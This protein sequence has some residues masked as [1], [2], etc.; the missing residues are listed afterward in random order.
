MGLE[1]RKQMIAELSAAIDIINAADVEKLEQLIT[2]AKQ[3][4]C[5]GAGRSGLNAK[6]FAMRLM[7]MGLKAFVVGDVVTPS[8]REGDVLFVISASGSS[9]NLEGT[10]RKAISSGAKLALITT[11]P[12]SVLC[13]LGAFVLISAPTKGDAVDSGAAVTPMGT[14]FEETSY[15]L[16]D[17]MVLD[18]MKMIGAKPE[19]MVY[20]HANLE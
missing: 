18:L 4:F 15:M 10:V 11:N 5:H 16:C 7:H 2:G 8:I 14:L 12:N 9:K 3:I 1:H 6:A 20:R 19:E 17:M 13:E